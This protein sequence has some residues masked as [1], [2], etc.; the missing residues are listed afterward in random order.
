MIHPR[1]C[2]GK[3]ALCYIQLFVS[4]QIKLINIRVKKFK[5]NENGMLTC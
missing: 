5:A 3:F 1:E 2:M 4:P